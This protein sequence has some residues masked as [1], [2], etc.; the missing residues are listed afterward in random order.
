[1]LIQ[2]G[3]SFEQ[4]DAG[5]FN[6]VIADIVDLGIVK[7]PQYGD[8]AKLRI[9]W[10]LDKNDSEGKPFR[11]IGTYNQ[12][13]NEKSTLFE[14]V[15]Q[16]LGQAPAAPFESETL[17]GKANQLFLVKSKDAKGKEYT[18]VK[19]VLPLPAGAVAPAIP[20]DFV[21]VKD[22]PKTPNDKSF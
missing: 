7:H 14:L 10:V 18:N 8:K 20:T 12:S 15:S 5:L 9:V 2:A 16:I 19:G 1:M 22:K 13:M 11:V 3:K 4:P 21:R 17:I 6:G